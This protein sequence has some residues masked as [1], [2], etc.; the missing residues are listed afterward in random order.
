MFYIRR[1]RD[2]RRSGADPNR[3][4]VV[5]AETSGRSIWVSGSP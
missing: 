3:A 4:L 2:E 5:A 1:E